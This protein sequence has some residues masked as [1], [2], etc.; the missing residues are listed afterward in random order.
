MLITGPIGSGKTT[1]ALEVSELLDMA[2]VAHG[3]V[4]VD[5]LRWCYPRLPDDPFRVGLAMR[6]LAAVWTNFRMFGA[7]SL[8]LADILTSRDQLRRYREAVPR[9]EVFVVRL[10]ASQDT[11]AARVRRREVGSGLDRHLQH[12]AELAL[13]MDHDKFE[14]L[15]VETDNRSVP[16]IAHEILTRS[17]WLDLVYT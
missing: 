10:R 3:M 12:A 8:I 2:G 14:D 17:E 1:V 5:A 11:L 16:E 13:Q 6:N 15:L 7:S 4:D 9:A